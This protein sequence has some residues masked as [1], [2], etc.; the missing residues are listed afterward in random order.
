MA[1]MNQPETAIRPMLERMVT[2]DSNPPSSIQ[3]Q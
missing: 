1:A 2:R 3:R